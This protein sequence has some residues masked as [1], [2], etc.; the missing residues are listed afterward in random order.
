M[1]CFTR[2]EAW[3]HL[4]GL[5]TVVVPWAVSA[6][7]ALGWALAVLAAQLTHRTCTCDPRPARRTRR[8]R[9]ADTNPKEET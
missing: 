8:R 4:G 2:E 6:L 1:T 9:T 7:I 5:V 3:A